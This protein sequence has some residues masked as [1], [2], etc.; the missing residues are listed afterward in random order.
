MEPNRQ[1][2]LVRTIASVC[3]AMLQAVSVT[4][5]ATILYLLLHGHR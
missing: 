4:L 2:E 3:S 1:L 5:S